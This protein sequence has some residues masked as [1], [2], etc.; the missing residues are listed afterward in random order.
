MLEL[1]TENIYGGKLSFIGTRWRTGKGHGSETG[2]V[3]L[4]A[5]HVVLEMPL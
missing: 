4:R 5:H 2:L 1:R 3:D